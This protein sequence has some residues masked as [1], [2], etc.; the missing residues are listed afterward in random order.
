LVRALRQPFNS[1]TA[2][3]AWRYFLYRDTGF[4]LGSSDFYVAIRPEIA[5]YMSLGLGAR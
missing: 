5:P 2:V 4:P 1:D 3:A